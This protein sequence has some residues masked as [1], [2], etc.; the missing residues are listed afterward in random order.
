MRILVV[1]DEP[2]IADFV[3]RS[4]EAAGYAV[5][6]VADG[7]AGASEALHGDYAL[8]L[9]DLMLPGRSGLDVLD[10]LRAQ[11]RQTPVVVLTARAEVDDKVAGLDRGANDY[12][13]KPFSIDELLARVRAQLRQPHQGAA[14][15]LRVGDLTLHLTTRTVERAGDEVKLTAREFELLA[16][17]MRHP[18]QVLS[19]SQILNSVWGYDYDPGTNVLDVYMSYLRRKLRSG[20]DDAPIETIRNAGYRLAVG[21]GRAPGGLRLRLTLA[22]CA[23][24]LGVVVCS[25]FVLRETTGAHL[26][27]SIDQQLRDQRREFEAALRGHADL[28]SREAARLA[29]GFVAAQR[30]HASSRI[31]AIQPH[32]EAVVTN[33]PE[34][35]KR[36]TRREHPGGDSSGG[37]TAEE[38][39]E[40][41][42]LDVH[43]G[44]ATVSGEETGRLRVLSAPILQGGRR[45]GTFRV[46]DPLRS[47]DDAEAGLDRAVVVVGLVAL[48]VSAAVGLAIATLMTRRLRVMARVASAVGEG[49]LGARIGD[50]DRRDEI[51]V[52]AGAFDRMLDRL[53]RAFAHEREFVSDASHELRTP[54]TVLRGQVELLRTEADVEERYRTIETVLRE[55]DA[56]NRL[57]DEM[58]TLAASE[59]TDLVRPQQIE[60]LGFVEDLRRD[61]PLLGDRAYTVTGPA[62]GTLWPIPTGCTRCCAT[63]CATP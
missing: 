3:C 59:S 22:I 43:D 28:S 8:I 25:F 46:A 55:L 39:G 13:I 24:S 15:V 34:L 61:L 42:L 48:L 54:L 51:G 44:L 19:R 49:D 60:I 40:S 10:A 32:G 12:M 58:L 47:V 30:Y 45:L 21:G 62:A 9:L 2:D 26:R 18:G 5:R 31:F 1:E 16:Y 53:E 52:L 63:S 17:L 6:W 29:R 7:D 35:L 37:E 56:M 50:V 57:I 20:S 38:I 27:D 11:D 33:Q 4:L 23:V 36:E 14:D 41:G